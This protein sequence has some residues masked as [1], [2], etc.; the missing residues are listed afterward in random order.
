[1]LLLPCRCG[2]T[3]TA[4]LASQFSG[5][6]TKTPQTPAGGKNISIASIWGMRVTKLAL[7]I[8]LFLIFVSDFLLI[9][10]IIIL[11]RILH[12]YVP[13]FAQHFLSCGDLWGPSL[14]PTQ[15]WFFFPL[16]RPGQ[17]G[18]SALSCCTGTA[19]ALPLVCWSAVPP[20]T[21]GC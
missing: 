21:W 17:P 1:M 7:K 2:V 14:S 10:S 11:L 6:R 18:H 9:L 15:L 8:I 19:S 20:F 13:M 5:I 12:F 3:Y 16:A 4:L